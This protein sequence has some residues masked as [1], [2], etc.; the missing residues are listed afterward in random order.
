MPTIVSHAVAA[1]A[2]AAAFPAS[3]IPRG[4]ILLA[5]MC[6][7]APDADVIGSRFG[8]RYG[9]L[10]GH[11]GLSHSLAFAVCFS[12]A[13]W[14]A[15][16]PSVVGAARRAVL[17]LYLLLATVSHGVLDAFTDGGLGVAF[18]S[19]FDPTRYFFPVRP[20]EESQK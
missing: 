8:I 20:I 2:L 3:V 13:A 17:W 19:P 1:T 10:L 12:F 14:P 6:A 9:D 7:M 5:S 15:V 11:R 18:F 4:A 16:F